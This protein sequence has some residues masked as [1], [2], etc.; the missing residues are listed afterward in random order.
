MIRFTL[1]IYTIVILFDLG[2]MDKKQAMISVKTVDKETLWYSDGL[3]PIHTEFSF[4]D[5]E[6]Y[7]LLNPRSN[8]YVCCDSYTLL[9]IAALD[10]SSI[11]NYSK[12]DCLKMYHT[13]DYLFLR[14]ELN[15][16]LAE[17]IHYAFGLTRASFDCVTN[18][19][20]DF[21]L[22]GLDKL[23]LDGVHIKKTKRGKNNYVN[24]LTVK[25][26]STFNSLYGFTEQLV[27]FGIDP[28]C[29]EYIKFKNVSNFISIH[30]KSMKI[31]LQ[32]CK[33]LKCLLIKNTGIQRIEKDSFKYMPNNCVLT[34][35]KNQHLNYMS[36]DAFSE[37]WNNGVLVIH[38]CPLLQEES[39]PDCKIR[40]NSKILSFLNPG[41]SIITD[42]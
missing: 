35:S 12:E 16:F 7:S 30:P 42:F 10:V 39:I 33:N 24:S 38:K 32:K 31:L 23:E 25:N 19:I 11:E 4:K 20:F 6:C 28:L 41:Y 5:T 40:R 17:H 34:L 1:L 36:E 29:L 13:M 22:V 9:N 2:A 18:Q 37:R 3:M 27:H 26:S 21:N 8:K 15:I 14:K